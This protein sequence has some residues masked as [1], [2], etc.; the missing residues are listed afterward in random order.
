MYAPAYPGALFGNM[1]VVYGIV[2]DSS[3][4]CETALTDFSAYTGGYL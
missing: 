3:V 2:H 1:S 4:T